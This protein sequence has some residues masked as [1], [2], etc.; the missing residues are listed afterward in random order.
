MQLVLENLWNVYETVVVRKDKPMAETI[1]KKLQLNVAAR[2][3]KHSDPKVQ[4]QNPRRGTI[5]NEIG[6]WKKKKSGY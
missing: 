3:L 5:S 2:D 6:R 1:V 4:V